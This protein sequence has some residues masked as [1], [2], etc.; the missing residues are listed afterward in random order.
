MVL[1]MCGA[2]DTAPGPPECSFYMELMKI[3]LTH[4]WARSMHGFY[5]VGYI[6]LN[7]AYHSACVNYEYMM[8]NH[9]V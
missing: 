3:I 4:V 7:Y 8:C 5:V 9:Q 2:T 1:S 6:M